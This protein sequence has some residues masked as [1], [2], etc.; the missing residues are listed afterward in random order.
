MCYHK[1]IYVCVALWDRKGQGDFQK[2]IHMIFEMC[3]IL[4][5]EWIGVKVLQIRKEITTG[6][7]EDI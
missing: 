2:K 6:V 4:Y 7:S 3:G 5:W 1:R